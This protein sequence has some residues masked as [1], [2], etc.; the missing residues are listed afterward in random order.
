MQ[1]MQAKATFRN[2]TQ[3][4]GMEDTNT[5]L[6]LG[7]MSVKLDFTTT[8]AVHVDAKHIIHNIHSVFL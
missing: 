2:R 3:M 5:C 4:Q 6:H 7:W 1:Y 8:I